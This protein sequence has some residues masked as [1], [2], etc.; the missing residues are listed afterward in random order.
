MSLASRDRVLAFGKRYGTLLWLA[1][2]TTFVVFFLSRHGGEL[3]RAGELIADGNPRWAMLMILTQFAVLAMVTGKWRTVFVQLGVQLPTAALFRAYLRRHFIGAMLPLGGPAG[4]VH[5]IRDLD[6]HRVSCHTVLHASLLASIVNQ[7]AFVLY[8][9][10]ALTWLA[11][12]GNVTGLMLIAAA[13]AVLIIPV[14]A[15]A[16]FIL[17][18]G[19]WMPRVLAK[20][21]PARVSKGIDDMRAEGF[22]IADFVFAVPYAIGVNLAGV[23]L[24]A[25]ALH[26][27][28]QEPAFTTVL[29]ARVAASVAGAVLPVFHG[30]GAVE[31]AI[32][33]ALH[34]GG[35]PVAEALAAT[36]LYRIVQLWIPMLLGGMAMVPWEQFDGS[37]WRLSPMRLGPAAVMLMAAI[38][39]GAALTAYSLL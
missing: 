39:I 36:V 29:T 1:I 5:F 16:L 17:I 4:L 33:G 30:A 9:I 3:R 21:L 24:L 32:I 2:L 37:S 23:A 25:V 38:P 15:G 20:R 27:I 34:A 26:A 7:V 8:L 13:G 6:R 31:A 35:V 18:R 12:A 11:L 28:G 22:R 10:P 14:T 19:G